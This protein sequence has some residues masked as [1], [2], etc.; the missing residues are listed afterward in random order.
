MPSN[1]NNADG[2]TA[3]LIIVGGIQPGWG[4]L[5]RVCKGTGVTPDVVLV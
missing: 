4:E 3:S 1:K 5:V 2:M